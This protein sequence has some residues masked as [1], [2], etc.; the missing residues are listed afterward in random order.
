MTYYLPLKPIGLY[1]Y[2]QIYTKNL[3][4]STYCIYA[5]CTILKI[6]VFLYSIHW[7]F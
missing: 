4:V 5:F 1:M 7:H 3:I 6:I 2:L